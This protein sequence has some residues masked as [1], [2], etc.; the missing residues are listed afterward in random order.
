[1]ASRAQKIVPFTLFYPRTLGPFRLVELEAWRANTTGCYLTWTEDGGTQFA[2]DQGGVAFGPYGPRPRVVTLEQG[3]KG[4]LYRYD[5]P[6]GKGTRL[7]LYLGWQSTI[8]PPPVGCTLES[9][10]MS[11]AE[12]IQVAN[13]LLRD[14]EFRRLWQPLRGD[15]RD[16]LFY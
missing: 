6:E 15:F 10:T 3:R 12:L 14:P 7:G 4:Y 8:D 13:M 5:D 2:L 1:M 9:R 11:E 16:P